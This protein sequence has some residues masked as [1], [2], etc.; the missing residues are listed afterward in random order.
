MIKL[1][2]ILFEDEKNDKND[3]NKIL[4]LNKKTGERY[5]ID[6]QN[7]DPDVHDRTDKVV[8]GK[9][10]KEDEKSDDK[11]DSKEKETP[12][13]QKVVTPISFI[14]QSHQDKI[15]EKIPQIRPDLFNQLVTY[16]FSEWFPVYDAI[17]EKS[18]AKKSGD[19]GEVKNIATRA[20]AVS[21]AK[22]IAMTKNK[23]NEFAITAGKQYRKNAN[24]IN[25]FLR[26]KT[27][28]ISKEEMM[29]IQ[30]IMSE[31]DK[32]FSSNESRLQFDCQTYKSISEEVVN[33][34]VSAKKWT[35]KS[36]VS[37]SL[38]PFIGESYESGEKFSAQMRNPLFQFNL[39]KG[40][41]VLMIPCSED[42]NCAETDITLP[43]NCTFR[44][45]SFNQ[46]SNIYIISVEF[47]NAAI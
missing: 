15:A 13:E 37:T 11:K 22:F 29:G 45:T 36:Y 9:K 8:V 30:K 21:L 28:G 42:V 12:T 23:P 33:K 3:P 35:D 17:I 34:F 40:D 2:D 38:N 31:L 32:F 5:Y 6:K 24:K 43:R 47:P 4:V 1:K 20:H 18:Y 46:E 14:D 10:D 27:D 44:I 26:G 16:N 41:P 7:F 19:M 25:S 39:K